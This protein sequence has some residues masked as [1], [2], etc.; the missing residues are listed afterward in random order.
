MSI[1]NE[2]ERFFHDLFG[3][4]YGESTGDLDSAINE[5]EDANAALETYIENNKSNISNIMNLLG[6][7]S[8]EIDLY[9]LNTYAESIGENIG[10]LEKQLTMIKDYN[11]ASPSKIFFS[12]LAMA[13]LNLIEGIA[14]FGEDIGDAVILIGATVFSPFVD[15]TSW[16]VKA[17]R[18]LTEEG[19]DSL[20]DEGFLKNI[21]KYSNF[22]HESTA[23]SVFKDIGTTLP[24][25]LLAAIPGV[26][27]AVE[28]TV[29]GIAGYGRGSS[30]YMKQHLITDDN[31][32]LTFDES[33]SLGKA[34]V[35]GGKEGIKDAALTLVMDKGFSKLGELREIKIKKAIEDVR[36]PEAKAAIGNEQLLSKYTNS[37]TSLADDILSGLK[38]DASKAGMSEKAL[39]EEADHL[40]ARAKAGNL[41]STEFK[42]INRLTGNKITDESITTALNKELAQNEEVRLVEKPSRAEKTEI[43]DAGK[44]AWNSGNNPTGTTKE[45]EWEKIQEM[46]TR[47]NVH[48]ATTQELE[49]VE[50]ATRKGIK[51]TPTKTASAP[52]E[53]DL[54]KKHVWGDDDFKAAAEKLGNDNKT[55]IEYRTAAETTDIGIK[56][57]ARRNLQEEYVR[58]FTPETARKRSALMDKQDAIIEEFKQSG[59]GKTVTKIDEGISQIKTTVQTSKPVQKIT[60]TAKSIANSKPVQKITE[61]AKS[62]ADSK[63][64]Q[65]IGKVTDK[66]VEIIEKYPRAST[67][68]AATTLAASKID[69][70]MPEPN[71]LKQTYTPDDLR[72][73]GTDEI[74]NLKPDGKTPPE[75]PTRTNLYNDESGKS[76]ITDS[77]KSNDT[78]TSSDSTKTDENT[79]NDNK[80]GTSTKTPDNNTTTE[81]TPN[82]KPSD[83]TSTVVSNQPNNNNQGSSGIS[84]GGSSSSTNNGNY[85]F[86]NSGISASQ[87]EP[88]EILTDEQPEENSIPSLPDEEEDVYTIP[89]DLSGATTTKK[90]S[91]GGSGVIPVL[92]GLGAA[93]AVG[94]GAKMYMDHKKNNDN[95]EDS[96]ENDDNSEEWNDTSEGNDGI[97]ADEWNEDDSNFEY[98]D[99]E[100]DSDDEESGFGEI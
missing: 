13:G 44:D 93:A 9:A 77:N 18:D 27:P 65:T 64:A 5:L 63:A 15:T 71:N 67:G 36:I 42:E 56:N 4:R 10:V 75:T 2:T 52:A 33:Y 29:A 96:D 99:S 84:H 73:I 3:N 26:G 12:T 43:K 11:D 61:T 72:K 58:K 1:V 76:T 53:T 68:I 94:V 19:F 86:T 98:E 74:D 62:V 38:K 69:L 17:A 25:I 89:T 59:A 21:E 28:A 80:S 46:K 47:K 78:T 20:Y 79:E 6:N 83:S 7:Y 97:L 70:N 54:W 87:D 60:E 32:N 55:V 39:K 51:T 30:D 34:W 66:T 40:A 82:P 92:G 24:Y 95:D 81:P 85:T 41:T 35:E 91:S 31:G 50:K 22:S 100:T 49:A 57:E 14:S 8:S 90:H 23:A 48:N 88:I 45:A 16:Q 37:E